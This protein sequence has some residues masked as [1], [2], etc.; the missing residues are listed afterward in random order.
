MNNDPPGKQKKVSR[1][2]FIALNLA[3]MTLRDSF[4]PS[5]GQTARERSAVGLD[6]G[7][8]ACSVPFICRSSTGNTGDVIVVGSGSAGSVVAGRLAKE[9]QRRV[10]LLEAGAEDWNPALRRPLLAGIL[11]RWQSLTWPFIT[12]PIAGAAD[13]T[14]RYPQGRVIG[15]G[16]SINGMMYVRGSR[17]N[18]DEWAE[19]GIPSWSWEN[20]LPVYRSMESYE[21]GASI[22]RGG[23]GPL[24]VGRHPASNVLYSV[25][26]NAAQ[27]AGFPLRADLNSPPFEGLGRSDCTFTEGSR[28]SAA[29]AFLDPAR[30]RSNLRIVTGAQ[31]TRLV[32]SKG[33]ATG[34]L[35]LV[36]G[37]QTLFEA[38]EIVISAGTVNS[39]KLLL[40]SGI[41]PADH[42][43]S[44]GIGVIADLPGVGMNLQDHVGVRASYR[45]KLAVTLYPETRMD[46]ATF[47]F[48][49]AWWFGSGP[50]SESPFG[51]MGLLRSLPDS[52]HPDLLAFFSPILSSATLRFPGFG[53]G[54][55]GE[56]YACAAQICQPESRGSVTL[57]SADPLAA[58]RIQPNFLTAPRDLAMLRSSLKIVRGILEQP[59]FNPYRGEVVG[60]DVP[61]SQLDE[62][63]R[64][65]AGP[66]LHD[67]GTCKMGAVGDSMTVVDDQLQVKGITGLRVADASVM[68]RVTSGNT[69]APSMMIG[70][71]CADFMLKTAV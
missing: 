40:L 6:D 1:R 45:S 56:G 35:A 67:V 46:R 55:D 7:N 18:F 16:S 44:M 61:D 25:F 63:I 68:P 70:Y 24:P 2:A 27:Q 17:A 3:A 10:I 5:V 26:L 28:W 15:G 43:R 33:K 64:R 53:D 65:H 41:G 36:D 19:M 29:R 51:A 52:P 62:W 30:D 49:R 50:V 69:N 48:F 13:R 4:S 59:A 20:V 11:S 23:G 66:G 42:L 39:P 37:A 12:E 8:R 71:R 54:Q 14:L 47:D 32:V 21:G 31:A 9:T 34:V 60:P 58:P 22:Y 38:D 57:R